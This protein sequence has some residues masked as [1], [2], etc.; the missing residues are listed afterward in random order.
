M[1]FG[2]GSHWNMM[3]WGNGGFWPLGMIAWFAVIV[4]VVALIV[5]A[6]RNISSFSRYEGTRHSTGAALVG[7]GLVGYRER[8]HAANGTTLLPIPHLVD[9]QASGGSVSLTIQAGTHAYLPG[10]PTQSF[11]YSAP[12]L[13]PAIRLR[14]GASTQVILE[15]KL[16]EPT[17][18]HWHGVLIPGAVDGGPH[19]LIRPGQRLT[20]TLYYNADRPHSVFG[21]RTPDEVYA[22]QATE[23]KLAA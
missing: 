11:G 5:W 16:D 10:L 20:A 8:T 18:V 17:T 19:N 15:N 13:G 2:Y 23:E 9:P 1:G 14:R 22:T 3:G 4:A 6:L 12:V 21:G 7:G